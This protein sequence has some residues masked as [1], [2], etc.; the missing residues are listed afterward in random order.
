MKTPFRIAEVIEKNWPYVV[1]IA[2]SSIFLFSALLDSRYNSFLKLIGICVSLSTIVLSILYFRI[3]R[4]ATRMLIRLYCVLAA[5]AAV[6]FVL[7]P[8][9]WVSSLL[10]G[11]GGSLLVIL[12]LL[13]SG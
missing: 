2:I 6:M 11:V 7:E 5:M 8:S 13:R 4:I 9:N 1:L 12:S 3:G 10:Y